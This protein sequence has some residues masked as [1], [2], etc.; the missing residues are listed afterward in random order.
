MAKR[1]SLSGMSE[2]TSFPP[3]ASGNARVLILGSM[4]GEV[5]LQANQYYAH[6][7]NQFWKLTGDLLG[8]DS[9][10]D[11]EHKIQSLIDAKIALWDVLKSCRRLGSL[12]ANIETQSVIINDF[13]SFFRRH[14][15]ISHVF[16]NG[17]KAEQLFRL[18]VGDSP[19]DKALHMLR[20]PST[21]PAHAHMNYE[22]K[23]EK[24]RV[25]LDVLSAD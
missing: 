18:Q 7:R 20:L 2:I 23:L 4:P 12:D 15:L 9:G 5:S 19:D 13:A 6:P 10:R 16:F 25:L 22:Q 24:W 14:P 1:I 8:F 11:Y 17:T 3:I 21:S